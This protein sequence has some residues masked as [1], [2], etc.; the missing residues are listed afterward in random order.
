MSDD[1]LVVDDKFI[2]QRNKAGLWVY[3]ANESV[4]FKK[5][6]TVLKKKYHDLPRYK[7]VNQYENAFKK[8]CNDFLNLMTIGLVKKMKQIVK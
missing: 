6:T 7:I 2:A 1:V 3:K 4:L 5:G 8:Q